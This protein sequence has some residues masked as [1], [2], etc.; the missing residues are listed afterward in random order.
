MEHITYL[1]LDQQHLNSHH[2]LFEILNYTQDDAKLE[3]TTKSSNAINGSIGK[4]LTLSKR[5]NFDRLPKFKDVTS[6]NGVNANISAA[7]TSIGRIKKVRFRDIGYDYHSDK[8][9]R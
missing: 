8:T 4:V 9:P 2:L 5:F 7:S 1:E 6:T 3:Y